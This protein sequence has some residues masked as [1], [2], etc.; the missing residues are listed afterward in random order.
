MSKGTLIMNHLMPQK[1]GL[2][3]GQLQTENGVALHQVRSLKW[4]KFDQKHLIFN[5]LQPFK[6]FSAVTFWKERFPLAITTH[7]KM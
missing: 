7:P 2:A 6:N 4:Q 5:T 3:G 1:S